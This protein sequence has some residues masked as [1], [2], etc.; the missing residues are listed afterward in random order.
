MWDIERMVYVFW[1]IVFSLFILI[2]LDIAFASFTSILAD[3]P[4]INYEYCV[5]Q[6]FD[7]KFCFD[8]YF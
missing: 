4:K 1:I 7:K 3:D 2:G 5:Q 8:K 6:E